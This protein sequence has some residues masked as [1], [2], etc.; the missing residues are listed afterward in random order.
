MPA[1][2]ESPTRVAVAHHEA[3]TRAGLVA[4]IQADPELTIIWACGTADEALSLLS[5]TP[6]DVT[7]LEYHLGGSRG[8]DL[9][10][11]SRKAG[12]Q[13]SFVVTGDALAN[14]DI[15]AALRAGVAG[16]VLKTD[17]AET[18]RDAIKRVHEGGFWVPDR[19][20][21]LLVNALGQNHTPR[22]RFSTREASVL[23][24]VVNGQSNKEIAGDLAISEAAVKAVN[25]RLFQKT[26]TRTR[27]QLSRV[28]L[29]RYSDLIESV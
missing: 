1:H 18:L 26:G 27:A 28:A 16:F 14:A 9:I 13:G 17:S 25:R 5:T 19:C 24:G 11:T 15:V 10:Y 22:M 23:R 8:A 7:L 4:L 12:F 6:I 20:L 21:K 3:L 29:E 2:V